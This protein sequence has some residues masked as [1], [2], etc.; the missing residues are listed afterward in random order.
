MAE[1]KADDPDSEDDYIAGALN[2]ETVD[3]SNPYI[4]G[5]SAADANSINDGEDPIRRMQRESLEEKIADGQL[6]IDDLSDEQRDLLGIENEEQQPK[7]NTIDNDNTRPE[8]GYNQGY[9]TAKEMKDKVTNSKAF[10]G[11]KTLG[12]GAK[13]LGARYVM[14][15]IGKAG[16]GLLKGT[17]MAIGAGTLGTI[18]VAAGLASED[19]GNIATYGA[20]AASIG[21]GLGGNI[22]NKAMQMP[23]NAYRKGTEVVDTFRQGAYSKKQYQEFINKRLDNEFIRSKDNQA[24][25]REKFGTDKMKNSDGKWVEAY[26]VAMEKAID[27]RQQGV[28]DNDTIIKA[29]KAKKGNASDDWAD[30]RRI[31][32][33]KLA[34]QVSNEKDVENIQKRLKEKGIR[35]PQVKA[36]ADMIREIKGLY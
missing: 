14:P 13:A 26:K 24:L 36:Q 1:R 25:Y 31:V 3:E 2:G 32:S 20:A 4:A 22:G 34:S 23:S 27:Y 33:A 16:K 29:M 10:K 7:I 19:Y 5:P 18:G 15:N 6:K 8:T 21:A 12:K 11:V 17:A 9:M 35:E 30:Q 28:T